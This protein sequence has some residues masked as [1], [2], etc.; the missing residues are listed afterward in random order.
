MVQISKMNI[1][2]L[3]KLEN[4]ITTPTGWQ[5]RCPACAE[6]NEDSR[7]KNH[8]GIQHDMKF[9]CLKYSGDKQHLARILQLVG[10]ESDGTAPIYIHEQKIELDKTWDID[11]LKKLSHNYSYF[12]NRGISAATQIHFKL[13]VALSG[14]LKGR[15]CVPI[16]DQNRNKIVG[17]NARLIDYSKWHK[18]NGIGKW[19]ILGNKKS[20]VLNGDAKS[21]EKT[22]TIIIVEGP[23]DILA[24]YE[25]GIKNTICLFGVTISSK[26]LGFLIK[27]NPKKIII[28]L[29]NESSGI[30]NAASEKLRRTLLNYFSEEC[31]TIGLPEGAKDF[32]E[33]L[34]T[35]RRSLIDNWSEKYLKI[36]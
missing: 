18:E 4:L 11:I 29:N 13:G 27:N 36:S 24:L 9:N 25:C 5:A 28:A 6:N 26:Q 34:E 2:D 16:F 22:R 19:K 10:T 12:E 30:G 21:I 33:L 15:V 20:F 17:F 23:A 31:V 8:L 32:C 1:I 3:E 35:G 14:Q 7:N